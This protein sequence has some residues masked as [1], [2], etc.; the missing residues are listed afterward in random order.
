MILNRI[1]TVESVRLVI[2]DLSNSPYVDLSGA[3]ML[4]KLTDDLAEWGATL[5][6]TEIHAEAR[7]LLRAENLEAKVG[8]I[9]RFTSVNDVVERF[10]ADKH[11]AGAEDR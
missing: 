5:R 1:R 9:D 8:R 10:D 3:R 7:D 4:A 6:L 2:G 11:G